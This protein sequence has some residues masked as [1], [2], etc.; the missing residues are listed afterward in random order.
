MI[1]RLLLFYALCRCKYIVNQLWFENQ[2]LLW[3]G[4]LFKI[5][6]LGFLSCFHGIWTS[7]ARF[8]EKKLVW[9]VDLSHQSEHYGWLRFW[10][11]KSKIRRL[12]FLQEGKPWARVLVMQVLK[13]TL[14]LRQQ[15]EQCEWLKEAK[16]KLN[17]WN[18]FENSGPVL[19]GGVEW[20]C[21]VGI[22][23]Q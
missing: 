3:L 23:W 16:S 4:A 19:C 10:L 6:K 15:S 12:K 21:L 8:L 20:F 9:T 17:D 2:C 22:C 14:E 13:S 1:L 5:L 18:I 11:L 7:R